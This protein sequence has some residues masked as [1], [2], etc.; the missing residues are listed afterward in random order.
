MQITPAVQF[1]NAISNIPA[2]G[3]V[4]PQAQAPEAA[5]QAGATSSGANRNNVPG[6]AN[7]NAA[8]PAN[9]PRGSI[10]DITV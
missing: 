8:P 7:S 1:I 9:A 6:Q 4:P 5:K 10:I 3:R 2:Q